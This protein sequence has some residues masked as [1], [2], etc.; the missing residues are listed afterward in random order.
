MPSIYVACSSACSRSASGRRQPSPAAAAAAVEPSAAAPAGRARPRPSPP[1]V[2]RRPPAGTGT[3]RGGAR[4]A[5]TVSGGGRS[6]L[7]EKTRTYSCVKTA[8][9]VTADNQ[10]TLSRIP[11]SSGPHKAIADKLCQQVPC[12]CYCIGLSAGR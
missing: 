5:A 2:G 11:I 4:P 7:S 8:V 12:D 6:G 10:A 9:R 1:G 3:C